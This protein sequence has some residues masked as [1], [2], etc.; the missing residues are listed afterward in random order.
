MGGAHLYLGRWG[1]GVNGSIDPS[2]NTFMLMLTSRHCIYIHHRVIPHSCS[3][4]WLSKPVRP[5]WVSNLYCSSHNK[6]SPWWWV[7]NVSVTL[8]ERKISRKK[9]F[10]VYY[11]VTQN[12]MRKLWSW[13]VTFKWKH[14]PLPFHWYAILKKREVICPF[15]ISKFYKTV[16]AN[17]ILSVDVFRYLI[18]HR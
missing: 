10:S 5:W 17:E 8:T 18:C 14:L 11:S 2:F 15:T 7:Q 4:Y 16:S 12:N 9:V 6:L 1:W 13:Y 3:E